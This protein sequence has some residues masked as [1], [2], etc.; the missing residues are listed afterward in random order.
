MAESFLDSKII[1]DDDDDDL[2]DKYNEENDDEDDEEH[3]EI[4]RTTKSRYQKKNEFDNQTVEKDQILL[5]DEPLDR[6]T[7]VVGQALRS[8]KTVVY[9]VMRTAARQP[10]GDLIPVGGGDSTQNNTNSYLLSANKKTGADG[11][12]VTSDSKKDRFLEP[13]RIRPGPASYK[14]RVYGIVE[15][16]QTETDEDIFTKESVQKVIDDVLQKVENFNTNV[17]RRVGRPKLIRPPPVEKPKEKVKEHIK[18]NIEV[19][20]HK[21]ETFKMPKSMLENQDWPNDS[22]AYDQPREKRAQSPV[23]QD[24]LKKLSEIV[25]DCTTPIPPSKIREMVGV[26]T[27]GRPP[28]YIKDASDKTYIKHNKPIPDTPTK[29]QRLAAQEDTIA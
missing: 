13:N 25:R 10:G 2:K 19:Q 8:G 24:V 26:S 27:R 15:S 5:Q 6:L 17:K 22:D 18:E 20:Q 4:S 23:S 29:Q 7:N 9:S 1:D 14:K 12:A 28:R 3:S 16:P 11:T 21:R